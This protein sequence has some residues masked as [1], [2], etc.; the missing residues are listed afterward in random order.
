MTIDLLA[1][2]NLEKQCHASSIRTCFFILFVEKL[3]ECVL[4]R[5]SRRH[6][7]GLTRTT[8]LHQYVAF[9]GVTRSSVNDCSFWSVVFVWCVFHVFAALPYIVA[10]ILKLM[11]VVMLPFS[12]TVT[13]YGRIS[14][15]YWLL[16]ASCIVM[17]IIMATCHVYC[18]YQP[19]APERKC[20]LM[21]TLC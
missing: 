11:T 20:F 15:V 2:V 18:C 17:Y 7:T 19:S 5:S 8:V 16:L 6:L 21:W 1:T 13:T 12:M 14:A 10:E 4:L 3:T 9:R